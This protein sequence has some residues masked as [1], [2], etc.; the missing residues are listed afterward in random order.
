MAN[1]FL[2]FVLVIVFLINF[3]F[4]INLKRDEQ[5]SQ[6]SSIKKRDEQISRTFP[7]NRKYANSSPLMKKDATCPSGSYECTD[8]EGGCCPNGQCCLPNFTCG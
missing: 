8:S 1:K 4:A 6:T 7:I 3:T 5:I 2:L